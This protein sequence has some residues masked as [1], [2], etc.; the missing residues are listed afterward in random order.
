MLEKE[1]KCYCH[2][3]SFA[4]DEVSVLNPRLASGD[5]TGMQNAWNILTFRGLIH[6]SPKL[7]SCYVLCREDSNLSLVAIWVSIISSRFTSSLL[8]QY[9]ISLSR[10][11]HSSSSWNALVLLSNLAP[12]NLTGN[13]SDTFWYMGPI[14][15]RHQF[16]GKKHG[17]FPRVLS[18]KKV[19]ERVYNSAWIATFEERVRSP[20]QVLYSQH[21][22]FLTKCEI[23]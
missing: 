2:N 22:I 21:F 18:A 15:T 12:S 13:S 1:I 7:Y 6:K 14:R 4:F 16:M 8:M 10:S 5:L 20:W 17:I 9:S 11:I 3:H 19:F 23:T